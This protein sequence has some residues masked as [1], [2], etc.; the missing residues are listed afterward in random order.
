MIF[1]PDRSVSR[2]LSLINIRSKRTAASFIG[3][4]SGRALMQRFRMSPIQSSSSIARPP[5]LIEF[6]Y[7]Y[8]GESPTY[9]Q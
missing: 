1:A 7:E 8:G 9:I 5:T 4:P 3:S 6:E 2:L